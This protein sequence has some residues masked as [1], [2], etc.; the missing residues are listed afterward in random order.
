MN[1]SGKTIPKSISFRPST[2]ERLDAAR[3]NVPRSEIINEI[4]CQYL[5]WLEKEGDDENRD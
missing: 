4:L 5:D 2:L 1:R 3:G